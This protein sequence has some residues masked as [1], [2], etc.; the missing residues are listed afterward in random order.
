MISGYTHFERS[1][2]RMLGNADSIYRVESRFYKN[3]QL[4][5]D[6]ATSTNGYATA[7]KKEFPVI[8]E[9]GGVGRHGRR[10][11]KYL[12]FRWQQTDRQCYDV[13]G[14]RWFYPGE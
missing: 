12:D 2:D 11:R 10:D 9:L 4:T 8:A 13:G 7:M 6:W 5:D 1:Y 14:D 3:D